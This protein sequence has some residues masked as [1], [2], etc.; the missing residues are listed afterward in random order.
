MQILPNDK[1]FRIPSGDVRRMF[2]FCHYL[3][4]INDINGLN[5]FNR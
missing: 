5:F 1:Q 4:K 3:Q 2:N